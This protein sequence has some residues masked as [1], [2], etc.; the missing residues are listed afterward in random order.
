[1]YLMGRGK[2]AGAAMGCGGRKSAFRGLVTGACYS[3]E[4]AVRCG[5][6]DVCIA[7]KIDIGSK[8]PTA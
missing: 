8:C 7:D 1:M 3:G 2:K 4:A 6:L 5:H